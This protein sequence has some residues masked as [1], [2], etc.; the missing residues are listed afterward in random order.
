MQLLIAAIIGITVTQPP[1]VD[2]AGD[3]SWTAPGY[4]VE[5]IVSINPL[6]YGEPI[7]RAGDQ[8]C[9]SCQMFFV[10]T[11]QGEKWRIVIVFRD[12]VTVLQEDEEQRDIPLTCTPQGAIYSRGGRYMLVQGS[13]NSQ[14]YD[15]L[16]SIDSG[17]VTPYLFRQQ[18]GWGGYVFVCDNGSTARS[19]YGQ[20]FR[21]D[22]G[23]IQI[24]DSDLNVL[25]DWE[26]QTT[27]TMEGS[28]NPI[29]LYNNG[30]I[31]VAADGSLFL[32]SFSPADERTAYVTA[33]DADG[34]I[35]WESSDCP[36]MLI[37]SDGEYLLLADGSDI[38]TM[39]ASTGELLQTYTREEGGL[40]APT[41]SPTGHA[42]AV[43][44]R[45]GLESGLIWG[46]D[47]S[48]DNDMRVLSYFSEEWDHVNPYRVSELG[49]VLGT[50]TALEPSGYQHWFKRF[51][52]VSSNGSIV[53]IS[54]V[55]DYDS[56][57][58]EA[59]GCNL[60][61]EPELGAIPCAIQTDGIRF[62][63]SDYEML[64]VFAVDGGGE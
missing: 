63:Y 56:G 19:S 24:I 35:L 13:L 32:R 12:K 47:P 59:H 9:I 15:E 62:A 51:A 16:I 34:D 54:T 25:M 58:F 4:T 29:H 7:R 8:A 18:T 49:Y 3:E 6:D 61:H 27:G 46:T 48:R 41:C 11:D 17:E 21:S 23:R 53:W 36:Y 57:S 20:M 2:Q 33:Y 5:E 40:N 43:Q 30:S 50:T 55:Y 64:R 45:H 38:I 1:L 14:P 39:D 37:T 60:N 22:P 42:W 52:L 44:L 28:R 31:G 26:D 10:D